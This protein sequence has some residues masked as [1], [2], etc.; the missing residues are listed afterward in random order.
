TLMRLS[1][2]PSGRRFVDDLRARIARE[3]GDEEAALALRSRLWREY[4]DAEALTGLVEILI[5][6]R[7]LDDAGNLLREAEA[8][9]LTPRQTLGAAISLAEARHDWHGVI[10]LF[11]P[12]AEAAP[13]L[14][15]IALMRRYANALAMLGHAAEAIPL[16]ERVAAGRRA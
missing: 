13:L 14:R 1:A 7:R 6:L 15:D 3:R 9:G 2:F 4:G 12:P 10:A 11:G 16:I 8:A 5:D